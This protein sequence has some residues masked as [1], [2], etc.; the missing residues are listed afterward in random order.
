M[1]RRG[2]FALKRILFVCTG[3]T[4]RS[5]MAEALFRH[6]AK[7]AGLQVEV[8]SAGVAAMDGAPISPHSRTILEKK[9]L[10]DDLRSRAV[11]SE[12]IAWADLILTMTMNH[13][14]VVMEMFPDAVAKAFTLKEYVLNSDPDVLQKM[15]EK[16]AIIAKLQLNLALNEPIDEHEKE[17]LMQLE[18]EAPSFDIADPFGGSLEDYTACATEIEQYLQQVIDKLKQQDDSQDEDSAFD[19]ND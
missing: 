18:A 17:R 14:R 6:M 8:R 5:P 19:S 1:T 15:E 10:T 13:K 16:E 12:D 7:Q 3:N 2:E 9:G 4:C 11:V